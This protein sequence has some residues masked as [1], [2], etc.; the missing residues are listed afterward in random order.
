[1][2]ENNVFVVFE[3]YHNPNEYSSI[4]G[5]LP[6]LRS[7][8]LT[9]EE[10]AEIIAKRKTN[11][12]QKIVDG[13]HPGRQIRPLVETMFVSKISFNEIINPMGLVHVPITE[14]HLSAETKEKLHSMINVYNEMAQ[15]NSKIS[16]PLL[17]ENR[18]Q[19][20]PSS[21]EKDRRARE[22]EMIQRMNIRPLWTR[23]FAS[24]LLES[25]TIPQPGREITIH[26]V[27]EFVSGTTPSLSIPST[28]S[29]VLP[30]ASQNPTPL[31]TSIPVAPITSGS[32]IN[33]PIVADSTGSIR[34]IPPINTATSPNSRITI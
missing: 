28:P 9:L 26:P 7:V 30:V 13:S 24:P 12:L 6:L 1:M 27:Q 32:S 3:L 23:R 15:P 17:I 4:E 5:K 31:N 34:Q 2:T 21:Y 16:A 33:N 14:A 20:D 10:A 29:S 18:L 25:G 22:W 19:V 11:E 8:C